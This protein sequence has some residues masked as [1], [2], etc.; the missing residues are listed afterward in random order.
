MRSTTTTR[1][2]ARAITRPILF[3]V[4][5]VLMA[6]VGL[7]LLAEALSRGANPVYLA[8]IEAQGGA[9]PVTQPSIVTVGRGR[10]AAPATSATVQLLLLLDIP[11]GGFNDGSSLRPTPGATPGAAER[12]EVAPVVAA[13]VATGVSPRDVRVVTSPALFAGN[14]GGSQI[15]VVRLD[16]EVARPTVERLN[17]LVGIGD[18]AAAEAGFIVEQVGVGYVPGDCERLVDDAWRGA[19][20]DAQARAARQAAWLGVAL[21]EVLQTSESRTANVQG[22]VCGSA[23]EF[24]PNFYGRASS[25]GIT[26]PP[27]DPLAPAEAVVEADVSV[28][29]AIASNPDERGPAPAFGTVTTGEVSKPPG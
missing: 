19:V 8:N 1:S 15:D 18:Q 25:V 26:V 17:E 3:G 10:V 13:L 11:Y 7:A 27:F 6:M 14:F 12:A 24:G 22:G 16:I 29:F 9:P 23:V 20:T 4:V 5:V 28:A 2:P 21:G